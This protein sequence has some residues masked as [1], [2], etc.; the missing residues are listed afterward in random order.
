MGSHQ[1]SLNQPALALSLLT[2]LKQAGLKPVDN[3]AVTVPKDRTHGDL[4]SDLALRAA[5]EN[6]LP[7]R[8]LADKI[9]DSLTKPNTIAVA[10]V[11][12]AGYLNFGLSEVGWQELLETWQE[13]TIWQSKNYAGQVVVVEFSSPNIGKPFAVGHLRS[14]I[15][16]SVTARL[17]EQSGAKV[18]RVNHIGDWGTQFGK[19]IYALN[20]WGEE[21]QL[22]EEPIKYL[23]ELYVRFHDEAE[24]DNSL[25]DQAREI[26]KRLEEGDETIKEQWQLVVDISMKEYDK[27]YRKLGIKFDHAKDRGES[28]YTIEM[29]EVVLVE[30]KEKGLVRKSEG[31]EVLFFPNDELPSTILKRSDGATVYLLRDLAALKY[32]LQ[33][34]RADRVIYHIGSEQELH[35]RQLVK[36]AELAGWL[37]NNQVIV[38]AHHGRYRLASG[39]M[40]TRKGKV[41]LL[42]DLLKRGVEAA[43]DL[44]KLKDS[45]IKPPELDE[46]A[47]KMSLSAIKY[48]DL[49]HN[50]TSPIIF[51]WGNALNLEGNSAPYLM[52][53]NARIHGLFRQAGREFGQVNPEV[54][55]VSPLLSSQ[56][57]R[58]LILSVITLHQN[59]LAATAKA[60]PHLIADGLFN[61]AQDFNSFYNETK[62]LTDDAKMTEAKLFISQLVGQTLASGLQ[63]LGVATPDRL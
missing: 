61:L 9:L 31:A 33:E 57:E 63:L 20:E 25:N 32:R 6:Q 30:L 41:I 8:E 56:K 45:Q 15:L 44:I 46:L 19:L 29:M 53:T 26:F 5:K 49:A 7:P 36:T 55:L 58:S 48:N 17:Y 3:F 11:A 21:E 35:F 43:R 51:E 10:K 27:L 37:D 50:R 60:L 24:K 2:A 14:T 59:F 40:S 62:I 52:Y 18:I 28:F 13:Q 22:A 12:G 39:E 1:D 38:T 34:W 54:S 4:T 16:G 47:E 42:D 23:L